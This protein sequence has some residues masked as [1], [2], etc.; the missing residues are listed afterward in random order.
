[1]GLT[2]MDDIV[3]IFAENT[4]GGEPTY[5]D[6][7]EARMILEDAQSPLTTRLVEKMYMEVIEKGH[8]DFDDIPVSAGDN[9][10]TG[11]ICVRCVHHYADTGGVRVCL[12]TGLSGTGNYFFGVKRIKGVV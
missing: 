4:D 3:K 11:R 6:C 10:G 7:D 1:M 9:L 12:G 2:V 5:A 8:I